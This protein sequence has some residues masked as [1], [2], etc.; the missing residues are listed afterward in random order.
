[1][2]TIVKAKS[3]LFQMLLVS[4]AVACLAVVGYAQHQRLATISVEPPLVTP[5]PLRPPGLIQRL[6]AVCVDSSRAIWSAVVDQSAVAL[7]SKI[8]SQVSDRDP[9]ASENMETVTIG[10]GERTLTALHLNDVDVRQALDMLGRTHGVNLL[11]AP[12]VEGQ[13]TANLEGLDFDAAFNALLKL[14]SLVADREQGLIYVYARKDYLDD[15]RVQSF[16]LDYVSV[17]QVHPVIETLLSANGHAVTMEADPLDNRKTGE[18]VVVTDTPTVLGR[19]AQYLDQVDVP[20]R[21]VMIEVHIL[22]IT[23]SD[24]LRHGINYKQALRLMGDSSVEL[25]IVGF[26]D[27]TTSPA[28]FARLASKQ[29]DGL[30]HLLKT[31][32]DAKTLASPRLMVINGQK[33][34]L[35]VGDQLPYR[36]L[37][38]TETASVEQVEFLDVGVV[39]EVTPRIG[40]DGRIL[41]HVKPQV[42]DGKYDPESGLPGEETREV[43]SDVLLEDGQGMVIGGLIQEQYSDIQTKLPVLGDLRWV[44]RLFQKRER[45]KERTEVVIT[46]VPRIIPLGRSQIERDVMDAE[47]TRTPLFHGPLCRLPRPWEP[48]L[49]DAVDNPR[50]LRAGIHSEMGDG[51]W[52][53]GSHDHSCRASAMQGDMFEPI[54]QPFAPQEEP[55]NEATAMPAEPSAQYA[56]PPGVVVEPSP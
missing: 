30:L 14:S 34:R 4:T 9:P 33:A 7:A 54:E 44:G 26:V 6:P 51:C 32:T 20:P 28:M 10:R 1:M 3:F 13:V 36:V 24:D 42:S 40:R 12:G 46:L 18:S 37:T 47:R 29:V 49:P 16:P 19:V 45:V 21:Q 52:N 2:P 48:S 53:G 25:D 17:V 55:A 22:Q 8:E 39:L 23:L 5:A 43:E 35:Q 50:N 31:T 27:P 11:I 56:L 38:L 41:M 15:I